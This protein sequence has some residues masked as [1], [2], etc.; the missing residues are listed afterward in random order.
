MGAKSSVK[1]NVKNAKAIRKALGGLV[2]DGLVPFNVGENGGCL[3]KLGLV[4]VRREPLDG[5]ASETAHYE[6]DVEALKHV[7]EAA[8]ADEEIGGKSRRLLWAV[9]PLSAE[10]V[11]EPIKKRRTVAGK[12]LR[13]GKKPVT[14]GTIRNYYEPKALDKLAGV[15][16]R[17]ELEFRAKQTSSDG[18][19]DSEGSDS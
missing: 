11:G 10:L 9:L 14:A 6:A 5:K 2:T 19:A 15:L 17:M 3:L 7:L 4:E 12:E 13:P 8:V 1:E 16:W 18:P